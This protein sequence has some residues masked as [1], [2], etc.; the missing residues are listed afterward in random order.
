VQSAISRANEREADWRALE[1]TRDPASARAL[2]VGF[3]ETS[4]GDPSPPRWAALL[5]GSHPTLADRVR[6]VEAWQQR[7][8]AAEKR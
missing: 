4:L 2:F 1:A 5:L 3:S 7:S 6:M 8:G